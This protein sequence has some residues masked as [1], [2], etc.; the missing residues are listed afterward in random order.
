[1][2]THKNPGLRQGPKPFAPSPKSSPKPFAK[3]S[4]PGASQ[5]KPPK[6]ELEGKKWLVVSKACM[7]Q[8]YSI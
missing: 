6:F 1:M 4:A 5:V 3:V 8:G 7:Y 2:K